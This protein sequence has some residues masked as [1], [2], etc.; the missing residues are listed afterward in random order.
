MNRTTQT[1]VVTV[2]GAFVL[3][4]CLEGAHVR[5]V[6]D[7]MFWP[8]LVCGTFLLVVP[9]LLAWAQRRNQEEHHQHGVPA[10]TWL[11]L[12][13]VAVA[14]AIS[15]PALGSYVAERSG[16]QTPQASGVMAP[17]LDEDPLPLTLGMFLSY[18]D[19]DPDRSL[20]DRRVLLEGFVS[21]RED[22][23]SVSRIT[24]S[25]CAADAYALTVQVH[26]DG[27]RP[28]RDT[29]VQVIGTWV[30]PDPAQDPLTVVQ[31]VRA[32]RVS[33][34]AEPPQPYEY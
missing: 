25:C 27:P 32:E 24:M 10:A 23:W 11:M 14:F 29:W 3:K 20:A 22:G 17:L 4:I 19:Y 18:A 6:K 30:E 8:L 21:H 15:P 33:E 26:A 2:I 1:L 31:A 9:L 13:P 28:A 16:G 7:W 12:A 34:I 5:F